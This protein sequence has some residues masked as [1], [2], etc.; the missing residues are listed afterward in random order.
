MWYN[1]CIHLHTNI[2]KHSK[3]LLWIGCALFAGIGIP[4]AIFF[5]ETGS[6]QA[7]VTLACPTTPIDTILPLPPAPPACKTETVSIVCNSPLNETVQLAE[8]EIMNKFEPMKKVKV[9]QAWGWG[10][11][12][13]GLNPKAQ[14]EGIAKNAAQAEACPIAETQKTINCKTQNGCEEQ[15]HNCIPPP[16]SQCTIVFSAAVQGGWGAIATCPTA[17]V[18]LK[19][20]TN[21]TALDNL[22]QM[23]A[24]ELGH[25]LEEICMKKP[26]SCENDYDAPC[27][28]K[29]K[30]IT[31]IEGKPEV[32]N[33]PASLTNR[34]A[35]Y[36]GRCNMKMT[37]STMPSIGDA[38]PPTG[39]SGP[40]T[41]PIMPPTRK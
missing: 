25:V 34:Q 18:V 13:G 37:C 10:F 21:Q 9:S 22:A 27:I 29:S 23:R 16:L 26:N 11:K 28:T 14:A 12:S 3:N 1:I 6:F 7:S 8:K 33:T 20:K 17:K 40:P 15:S 35:K 32:T 4:L 36:C 19:C 41:T 24:L 30:S 2:M 38:T 39:N 31:F 5:Q